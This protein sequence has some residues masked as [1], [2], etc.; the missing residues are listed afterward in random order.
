MR[1]VLQAWSDI[2]LCLESRPRGPLRTGP[3]Q[4]GFATSWVWATNWDMRNMLQCSFKSD[5]GVEIKSMP[6]L[7]NATETRLLP[8]PKVALPAKIAAAVALQ[9]QEVS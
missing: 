3:M 6:L 1:S 5:H 4:M 2:R 7:T 8:I 9:V